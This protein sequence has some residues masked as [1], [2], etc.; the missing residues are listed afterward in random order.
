MICSSAFREEQRS[1]HLWG[2]CGPHFRAK[3]FVYWIQKLL[4]DGL[5]V[6]T[7]NDSLV[8]ELSFFAE[9]HGKGVVDGH[10]GKL[11]QWVSACCKTSKIIGSPETL[12][13]AFAVGAAAALE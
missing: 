3:A 13:R 5:K 2:D 9:H 4:L 1:S 6:I 11:S 10:F 8:I 12:V 7:G